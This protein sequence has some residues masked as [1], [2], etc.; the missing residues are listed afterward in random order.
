MV[1]RTLLGIS[2]GTRILGLAVL[3]N[4][5]LVEWRVKTYK[6]KWTK[7]KQAAILSLIEKLCDYYGVQAMAVKKIDPLK[8]SKQ[9]EKLQKA[10]ISLAESKHLSL[11]QYSLSDLD[12]DVRTGSKQTKGD[13]S[14]DVAERHPELKKEYLKE[15]NNRREYYTKMF[16]A[17]AMAEAYRGQ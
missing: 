17:I 4:G 15:R 16:E 14:E 8:S 2:P 3:R 12:Y 5:E 9:S 10:I 7:E 6:E 13:L 11:A 1:T